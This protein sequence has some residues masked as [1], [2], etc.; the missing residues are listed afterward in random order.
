[1]DFEKLQKEYAIISEIVAADLFCRI[2]LI[3]DVINNPA[4]LGFTDSR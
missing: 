3:H 4:N 1:M 2:H